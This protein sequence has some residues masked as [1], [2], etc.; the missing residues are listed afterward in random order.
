MKAWVVH[1]VFVAALVTGLNAMKP[2]AVDDTAYL[3]LARQ[4]AAHPLDPYGGELFWYAVPEPA[5]HVLA[6][7][8]LPYWLAAGIHLFGEELPLLKLWLFPFPLIL[9]FAVRFLARH[10]SPRFA[11]VAVPAIALSPLVLPLFGVML[12][13]P[14]LSLSLAAL[15]VF[16]RCGKWSWL[17]SGVL[18]GL[19]MQTKYTAFVTPGVILWY[20]LTHRR[21]IPALLTGLVAVGLFVAWEG[22]IDSRYGESHFLYHARSQSADGPNG[23]DLV[24]FK[25]GRLAFPLLTFSGGLGFGLA[26][27]AI[28]AT[29]WKRRIGWVVFGLT[30]GLVAVATLPYS[31]T[32][33]WRKA[34]TGSVRLDL[35]GLLFTLLGVLWLAVLVRVGLPFL[36]RRRPGRTSLFLTG[37]V[38]V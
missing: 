28:P 29:G 7:P 35:A 5:L 22:L 2:A 25:V 11:T 34:D 21:V 38:R 19:A 15:A 31:Q 23:W 3:L 20:G 26:L 13:V 12:D 24:E 8:V 1:P 9:C 10:F 30:A 37:W 36:L 18:A 17:F 27:F 16:V 14:A 6:P 4:I 33:F 32:V